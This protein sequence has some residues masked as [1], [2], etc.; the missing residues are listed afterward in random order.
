MLVGLAGEMA[1]ILA[2]AGIDQ[3]PDTLEG[4]GTARSW[5]AARDGAPPALV[6]EADDEEA[7]ALSALLRPL[8]HYGRQSFLVFEGRKVIEKG[9]WPTGDNALT[10]RFD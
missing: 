9:V 4:R 2:K 1:P 5:V 3:M 8:P 10:R 6:V 7:L